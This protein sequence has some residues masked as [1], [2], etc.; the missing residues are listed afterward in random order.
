MS[1]IDVNAIAQQRLGG[2]AKA[3]P[4]EQSLAMDLFGEGVS[5]IMGSVKDLAADSDE[6]LARNNA[7][8]EKLGRGAAATAYAT[9]LDKQDDLRQE[10]TKNAAD[11]A[12]NAMNL[13]AALIAKR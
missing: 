11:S 13:F 10:I 3:G 12:I 5:S 2:S 7:I 9:R 4:V 6:S 8:R 1:V